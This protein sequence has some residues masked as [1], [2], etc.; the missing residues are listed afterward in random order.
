MRIQGILLAHSIS[1]L[2]LETKLVLCIYTE[3]TSKEKTN[4][5]IPRHAYHVI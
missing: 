2:T 4:Y 3:L 1:I 5:L